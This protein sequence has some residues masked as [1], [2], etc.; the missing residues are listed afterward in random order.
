MLG[1][2]MGEIDEADAVCSRILETHADGAELPEYQALVAESGIAL[3]RARQGL[4]AEAREILGS[5]HERRRA[6]KVDNPDAVRAAECIGMRCLR[7]IS[8]MLESGP[9]GREGGGTG[10]D[11]ADEAMTQVGLEFEL[12]E[13]YDPA[14]QVPPLALVVFS[15]VIRRVGKREAGTLCMRRAVALAK[16][17]WGE[18]HQ[19]RQMRWSAELESLERH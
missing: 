1:T 13:L 8:L 14:V 11:E 3:C 5:I 6:L 10:A 16:A 15:R 9:G 12:A 18:K 2:V 4:F 17:R 7:I 19:R